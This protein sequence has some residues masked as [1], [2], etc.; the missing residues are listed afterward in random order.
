LALFV[1][2]TFP[3]QCYPLVHSR[4]GGAFPYLQPGDVGGRHSAPAV[5]QSLTSADPTMINTNHVHLCADDT[6]FF[7]ACSF[8]TV[9]HRLIGVFRVLSIIKLAHLQCKSLMQQSLRLSVCHLFFPRHTSKTK[10]NFIAFIENW[11]C[12]ARI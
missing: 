5:C 2:G 3:I 9:R 8:I 10:Q 7:A 12:R 4:G 11:G 1:R 6:S